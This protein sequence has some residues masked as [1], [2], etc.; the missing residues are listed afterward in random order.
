MEEQERRSGGIYEIGSVKLF[1]LNVLSQCGD[2]RNAL[3]THDAVGLLPLLISESNGKD[4]DNNIAREQ[5]QHERDAVDGETIKLSKAV[6]HG[7]IGR[8]EH[9]VQVVSSQET[10][11]T[12]DK[13][14]K[15]R[16]GSVRE[17]SV[18]EREREEHKAARVDEVDGHQQQEVVLEPKVLNHKV[19]SILGGVGEGESENRGPDV[20]KIRV[21]SHVGKLV[22][23]GS[24][25][26]EDQQEQIHVAGLE[27][28]QKVV[29][30]DLVVDGQRV[31]ST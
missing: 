29:A 18:G 20:V 11:A 16:E 17:H 25:H 2:L 23:L 28:I 21:E 14:V 30:K 3:H 10:H 15:E 1:D 31:R 24:D 5:A 9:V 26:G 12:E 8:H 27:Q 19:E 13:G 22:A 6:H 4:L 7:R